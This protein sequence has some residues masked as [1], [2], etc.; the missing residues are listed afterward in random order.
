MNY[1]PNELNILTADF[2]TYYAVK[3]SLKQLGT[4]NYVRDPRFKAHGLGIQWNDQEP[5]WITSKWIP[6]WVKSVDW[7][8][9][10]LVCHNTRFDAF[11]LSEI[12]DVPHGQIT[13]SDT[14]SIA[15]G[16]LPN[17]MDCSLDALGKMFGLGQKIEGALGNT[18]GKR[19]LSMEQEAALA[20]YCLQDVSLTYKL[21]CLLFAHL[22]HAEHDLVHLHQRMAVEPELMIDRP[23]AAREFYEATRDQKKAVKHSGYSKTRLSSNPQF[24]ALLE[25]LDIEIPMKPNPKDEMVPAF[26][27]NDL[28]FKTLM[29]DHPEHQALWEGRI[30]AKSNIGITRA[31]RWLDIHD[32]GKGTLPMPLNYYGAH[33]G[34]S[35][36]ADGINVQNLP[37]MQHGNPDSGKLRRA[38]IAPPGYVVVVAD[39]SQIEMRMNMWLAGQEDMLEV[40]RKGEDP[41]C[42]AATQHFGYLCEKKTHPNERQFGKMLELALGFAMGHVKFRANAALGFMGCPPTQLSVDEAKEAVT[43]Y[44]SNK[45][46]VKAMWD[47]LQQMLGPMTSERC[48][49][50]YKC[51]EF[52]KHAIVLPNGMKLQYPNLRCDEGEWICGIGKR[53][54]RV[55]GGILD[56]NVVQALARIVVFYQMLEIDRTEGIHVVSSTHDEVIALVRKAEAQA[57]LNHMVEVMSVSPDW[58]PDLPLN[59]EGGFAREYSK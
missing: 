50:Q 4:I 9:V 27:M 34:R 24:K 14:L 20:S 52:V 53:I 33:T 41:Y 28:G 58:A 47:Y 44:R 46:S 40:F 36:G 2:E 10:F 42:H 54:K 13:Y 35:S 12:Y 39:S 56:E 1:D 30:A 11:I 37:R 48:A 25:S 18:K 15:R 32:T 23:L 7:S 31:R 55:Y 5:E 17:G 19:H 49:T 29:A 26:S 59:A 38:I 16:L 21:F 43:G 57:A 45:D 22:P 6:T 8:N 3:Y 51:I